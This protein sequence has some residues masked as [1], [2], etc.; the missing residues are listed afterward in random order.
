VYF[1][2]RFATELGGC[3]CIVEA[4]SSPPQAYLFDFLSEKATTLPLSPKTPFA[5]REEPLSSCSLLVFLDRLP[6]SQP[7]FL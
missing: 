4:F 5:L 6:Q 3:C 2:F 7:F 1:L